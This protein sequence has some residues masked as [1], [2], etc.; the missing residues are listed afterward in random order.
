M[1]IK[2]DDCKIKLTQERDVFL[3]HNNFIKDEKK[4]I[5]KLIS[6]LT[7]YLRMKYKKTN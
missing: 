2:L 6:Q 5:I 7:W 1:I 3:D 4:Q